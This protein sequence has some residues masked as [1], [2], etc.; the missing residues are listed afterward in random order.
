MIESVEEL[1][2]EKKDTTVGF[3]DEHRKLC[4]KI[5][6]PWR[7]IEQEDFLHVCDAMN[8]RAML[9]A[10]EKVSKHVVS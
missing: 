1:I 9:I 7:H 6:H 8:E 4:S 3:K 2:A 10:D 5:I